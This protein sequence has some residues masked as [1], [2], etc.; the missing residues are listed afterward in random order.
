MVFA[1]AGRMRR[2]GIAGAQSGLLT[3]D[4][5]DHA[6]EKSDRSGNLVEM[7]VRTEE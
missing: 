5:Q 3:K 2:Q 4:N 7:T 1:H 6:G